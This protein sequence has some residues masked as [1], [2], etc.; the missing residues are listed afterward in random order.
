MRNLMSLKWD[1]LY[2]KWTKI[3]RRIQIWKKFLHSCLVTSAVARWWGQVIW[4]RRGSTYIASNWPQFEGEHVSAVGILLFSFYSHIHK[5]KL[6]FSIW[7]KYFIY[8]IE[9][10]FKKNLDL[11]TVFEYLLCSMCYSYITVGELI[12]SY[13]YIMA[14]IL[15]FT[16][17][18][19]Y[20]IHCH[21]YV[22]VSK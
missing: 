5:R 7:L 19:C 3:W 15:F 6:L 16:Y 22:V 8:H 17:F 1:M 10:I 11:N 2:I 4:S 18:K 9:H 14:G 12:L 20:I 13:K 21:V